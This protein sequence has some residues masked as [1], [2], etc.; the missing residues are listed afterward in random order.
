MHRWRPSGARRFKSRGL[1]RC[2]SAQE[3]AAKAGSG[4]AGSL[5]A[6]FPL[7]GGQD[8]R[9]FAVICDIRRPPLVLHHMKKRLGDPLAVAKR[10]NRVGW[11]VTCSDSEQMLVFGAR[12]D[13]RL[14]GQS[15]T[16]RDRQ[17]PFVLGARNRDPTS[18][19]SAIEM[20]MRLGQ[21]LIEFY[22][23]K[24]LGFSRDF[25]RGMVSRT[26]NHKGFFARET[27]RG[28]FAFRE[29]P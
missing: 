14:G 15:L 4:C 24:N 7:G 28:F 13:D 29:K 22:V 2:R 25:V 16:S 9:C 26:R 21:P 18:M 20:V 12:D 19:T 10:L 6:P 3:V 23:A 11:P 5:T 8:P 17:Q 1:R 27:K